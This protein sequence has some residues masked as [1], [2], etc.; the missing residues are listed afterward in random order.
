MEVVFL[1][2]SSQY[3]IYYNIVLFIF[4]FQRFLEKDNFIIK[5]TNAKRNV[6]LCLV[7]IQKQND[8]LKNFNKNKKFTLSSLV[9]SISLAEDLD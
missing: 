6:R 9:Y 3:F 4:K 8:K 7:G 5:S 2:S 1:Q